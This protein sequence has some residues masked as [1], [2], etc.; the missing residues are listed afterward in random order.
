MELKEDEGFEEPKSGGQEYNDDH[1]PEP[2]KNGND[3]IRREGE[4]RLDS[5][6][7]VVLAVF[8][9]PLYGILG[10]LHWYFCGSS[11]QHETNTEV[12]GDAGKEEAEFL[13]PRTSE[14]NEGVEWLWPIEDDTNKDTVHRAYARGYE[15]GMRAVEKRC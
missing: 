4:V 1:K 8:S 3:E 15:D 7:F 5:L 12:A 9:C 6:V 2:D 11:E 10:N 13:V 14:G